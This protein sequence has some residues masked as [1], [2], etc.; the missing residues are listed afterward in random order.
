MTFLHTL[1]SIFLRLPF[2]CLCIRFHPVILCA[3]I[4]LHLRWNAF[5]F[6]HVWFHLI[7]F[8]CVFVA[9]TAMATMMFKGF[10]CVQSRYSTS[11]S[12][13]VRF[14]RFAFL[15]IGES[16]WA[17]EREDV[18]W[19]VYLLN[20][21]RCGYLKIDIYLFTYL[22]VCAR[23]F[24]RIIC[25]QLYGAAKECFHFSFYFTAPHGT[26]T[27][28]F[29]FLSLLL[30]LLLRSLTLFLSNS[31]ISSVTDERECRQK[32]WEWSRRR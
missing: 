7:I 23:I 1:N 12:F 21:F 6:R 18:R 16:K 25:M 9:T 10:K 32:V 8:D 14:Y 4:L 20:I 19:N 15:V 29:F 3:N 26:R 24:A 5:L 22:C 11:L 30:A 2:S 27:V 13:A 31:L 17:R 28:R